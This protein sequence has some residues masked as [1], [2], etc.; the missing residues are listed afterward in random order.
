MPSRP[1][2]PSQILVR[3]EER[4]GRWARIISADRYYA[5][6]REKEVTEE[7]A[8]NVLRGRWYGK[9]EGIKLHQ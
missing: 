6:C 2:T 5:L 9:E 8:Q 1:R 4:L 7:T 3:G